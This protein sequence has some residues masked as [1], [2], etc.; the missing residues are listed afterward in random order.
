MRFLLQLHISPEERPRWLRIGIVVVCLLA[1]VGCRLCL[2]PWLGP[3]APFALLMPAVLVSAW[4][5]GIGAGLGVTFLGGLLSAYLFLYTE[6][7]PIYAAP[8]DLITYLLFVM[9][10]VSISLLIGG[11][12]YAIAK[13]RNAL[14]QAS[15]DFQNMAD[16]A[17]VLVWSTDETG[18]TVFVNR[19]WRNFTGRSLPQEISDRHASI[20][21]DDLARVRPISIRAMADR[22]D[23]Q[24]EYRLRRADGVYQWLLEHAVPRYN[25][26]RAFEGYIGSCSD[27]SQSKRERE[28]L[29]FI[30]N[31][32]RDLAA[33]RSFENVATALVKSLVPSQAD[34]CCLYLADVEGG[35]RPSRLYHLDPVRVRNAEA[36]ESA[37]DLGSKQ[38]DGIGRI[39]RENEPQLVTT[40]TDDFLRA[41]AVNDAHFH[42]LH[43]L[44][45]VS[46]IGV[47]LH[48]RGRV[49]GILTL[50]TAD[51]ERRLGDDDF[52]LAKKIGVIAALVL[53]NA[54]LYEQARTALEAE[55]SSSRRLEA[56]E[57]RFRSVWDSNLIG[58]C[59]TTA[60]GRITGANNAFLDLIGV[61]RQALENNHVDWRSRTPP[62][63]R[64]QD[65][66]AI[67]QLQTADRYLPYEKEFVRPDGTRNQVLLFGTHLAG[68]N[69]SV[70]LVLD[71]T[72]KKAAES[73]LNR[74]RIL[75]KTIIDAVPAMV[76]YIG[77]D[78]HF[79]VHNRQYEKWTGL[80]H[81][82]IQDK[83]VR[84]VFGQ[85]AYVEMQ[86]YLRAAL[87]GQHV[88]CE[89]IIHSPRRSR[90]A[91]I[92]YQP[93]FDATGRVVGVVIHAYDITES[94]QM[95]NAVARSEKRYH[96][97]VT[98]TAAIVWVADSCGRVVETTGWERFTGQTEAQSQDNGW[99]EVLHPEDRAAVAAR[100]QRTWETGGTW[101]CTYRLRCH[102]GT[103]RHI[104]SRGAPVTGPDGIIQEWI[105]T[106]TD[107][108]DR[109][110]AENALRA[111]ESEFKLIVNAMPALVAYVDRDHRYGLANQA[112]EKWFDLDPASLRGQPVREVI[113][114]AAYTMD[115][116][117]LHAVMAGR[118]VHFESRMDYLHGPPR[119]ISG[120]YIPHVDETSTVVG[121][122]ALLIDITE[123]K[124][125]EQALA[126]ALTRYRFLADAMP[127][128]VW[129]ARPDGSMDYV[130]SRWDITG[131]DEAQLLQPGGWLETLHPDDRLP[132]QKRWEAAVATCQPWEHSFRLRISA[133]GSY[134][135]QL[136]RA[137]PRRNGSG[138]VEQWV[139]TATD[140]DTQ[141]RAY[142]ELAD[143]REQLRHHADQLEH[144]VRVRTAGLQEINAELEAFS[145]SVSHD[146]RAPLQFVSGFAESILMDAGNHLTFDSKDH[147]RRILRSAGRMDTIINDLL[148]YSRLSR[149]E[150][151]IGDQ[152]LESIVADVIA[153]HHLPIQASVGAQ[154][155]VASP[156]PSVRADKTGL[157]QALSNLLSNALKFTKPG[158]PAVIRI[159]AESRGPKVRLWVEDNGI[160]IEAKNHERIFK[161]FE[162]LHGN[163]SYSGS[164]VGL[165]L[166]RKAVTRMG[167]ACG[168]ESA[169]GQGSRFW[170]DFPVPQPA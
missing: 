43:S 30:A 111:K 154:V 97:L 121:C 70:S 54:L 84:E 110:E 86:P 115:A 159:R 89:K 79:I 27:I 101:D 151:H 23:Y 129:T 87:D 107:I 167:G 137:I 29:A 128:L 165:S 12:H 25:Q 59:C 33:S 99:L 61:G 40:V 92:T 120:A 73:A 77:P 123:R 1:A 94:R 142:A 15:L 26:N 109:V 102:D 44:K 55:K 119:W 74:Q 164:G 147:L 139:G 5:G 58:I 72:E 48:V 16:H 4:W 117:R 166:V 113:G 100:W 66:Y 163:A 56:S 9:Q 156:L 2:Q 81:D 116:P 134:R 90:H 6:K 24:V 160:G 8:A 17:A 76:A 34:W 49:M 103:Y 124:Q 153:T 50:A 78:E 45:L 13:W 140:I 168:V 98:T 57:R 88:R 108:H 69:E 155:S 127:E 47:P 20:H 96:T 42:Y 144:Q 105:G 104:H 62:E 169:P 126:D 93:D 41:S 131:L 122:I 95:A 106:I 150:M 149:A 85:E 132:T 130:N 157:F 91:M 125:T 19:N 112:Y 114:E 68:T 35:L 118:E 161:L 80:T 52:T 22:R 64:A 53:D 39:F 141:R 65:E 18:K 32:H 158:Q 83:T 7:Y 14:Q 136:V 75:L 143:A 51:S 82:E 67:R 135:W 63:W 36:A 170:I 152:S 37:Y 148:A 133:N 145:Y 71:L 146:L 28:R 31:L 138:Q 46:F 11:L 3:K 38:T 162:R 21:P 10:G 60:D